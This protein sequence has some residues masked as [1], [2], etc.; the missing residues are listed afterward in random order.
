MSTFPFVLTQTY[1]TY[2]WLQVGT[3]NERCTAPI[4]ILT[5]R[6]ERF[7]NITLHTYDK[8]TFVFTDS[9]RTSEYQTNTMILRLSLV[10][11]LLLAHAVSTIIYALSH[12]WHKYW[13]KYSRRLKRPNVAGNLF[14]GKVYI[15]FLKH[16]LK[17]CFLGWP[18]SRD[19]IWGSCFWE[20]EGQVTPGNPFAESLYL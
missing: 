4:T 3:K 7:R 9:K 12:T 10:F 11:C 14:F 2:A 13:S 5:N 17:R 6:I 16:K 1:R 20:E 15:Q 19:F 8:I 18:I